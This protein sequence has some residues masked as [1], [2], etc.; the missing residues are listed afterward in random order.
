LVTLNSDKLAND[1]SV[2]LLNVSKK[3]VEMEQFTSGFFVVIWL[4]LFVL[5][6]LWFLLPFAIFGT[7][8]KL[9]ELINEIKKSN[10]QLSALKAEMTS[11]RQDNL[12]KNP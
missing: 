6:I 11:I 10:T 5:A 4:F 2:I 1:I 9:D 12:K 3:E 7:K 8:D